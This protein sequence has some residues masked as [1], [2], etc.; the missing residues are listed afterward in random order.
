MSRKEI[1]LLVSRALAIIQF[2]TAL[3]E[4]SYLPE[5]FM[6]LLRHDRL[7]SVL[8][9]PATDAWYQNY[10]RVVIAFLFLRIIGLLVLTYI[11]WNCAPWFERQLLPAN[12]DASLT[13]E[14][15]A[16]AQQSE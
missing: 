14:P 1:V 9:S 7:D 2:V 8:I 10:Y 12:G 11:F 5:R 15:A 3:L 13:P 4:I 16:P 6:S